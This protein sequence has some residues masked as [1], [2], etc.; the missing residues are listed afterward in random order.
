[1][2]LDV[3][4][5]GDLTRDGEASLR[6]VE[7]A[8]LNRK[9]GYRTG[10]VHLG[11]TDAPL[12]PAIIELI[13]GKIAEAL[14]YFDTHSGRLII[15]IDPACLLRAQPRLPFRLTGDRVVAVL[16][17]PE[18]TG[19][20]EAIHGRLVQLLGGVTS[21]TATAYD[22]LHELRDAGL[23]TL[24]TIWETFGAITQTP[25][26]QH[27]QRQSRPIVGTA[28]FE[29]AEH[30]PASEA[31]RHELWDCRS[32]RVQV[33]GTPPRSGVTGWQVLAPLERQ[34]LRFVSRLSAFLYFPDDRPRSLPLTA[35]GACLAA[36]I[37][38]FVAPHLQPAIGIGPRY[39]AAE[40]AA[41]ALM[42]L[43]ADRRLAGA[44][45]FD[46]LE[47]HRRRMRYWLGSPPALRPPAHS[48]RVML[49]ASNGDGLG[50]V[51]RLLAIARKLPDDVTPVFASLSS[52]IG[53]IR[54]AGF[55]AE[56]ILSHRYANLE[57]SIAY[58]W[59]AEELSEIVARHQPDAFV[60]D[61]GNPYGFMTEV[62]ARRRGLA[63]L[64]LRR[65]MWQE[66]QNNDP[67]LAKE[68]YF[69]AII[70]PS[71]LAGSA[72]RGA[73][74]DRRDGIVLTN[75]IRLVDDDEM[76]SHESA[77][78]A[79]GLDPDR[80]AVLLQLGIGNARDT[81]AATARVISELRQAGVQI[82]SLV[83]PMSHAVHPPVPGV[84]Q[85]AIYPVAPYLAA[86]DFAVS[87]AGYNS[88]HELLGAGIPT[89]F[90]VTMRAELD[91]QM[92]R[93]RYAE[94]IGAGYALS[95]SDLSRLP[96]VVGDVLSATQAAPDHR[97]RSPI[98]ANGA[99][100]AARLIA[101]FAR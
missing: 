20:L 73:T 33:A 35:I 40:S 82:V 16:E 69:E 93:A 94:T 55:P 65:G 19:T 71:D 61:G 32:Y 25:D 5:L 27:W 4:Y 64:W 49:F 43:L 70:E 45:R 59:M 2:N 47:V 57:P 96:G 78:E 8:R 101:E 10:L 68:K 92:A 28:V 18:P 42:E 7:E 39:V 11:R 52:G 80:P 29:G 51:T 21:W 36:G 22:A 67:V 62:I 79:L 72:D 17:A 85:M 63:Y 14:D 34:H 23:A 100:E 24:G 31:L 74:A 30:W 54:D 9:L 37:P 91:D 99:L 13:D 86:F 87:A 15:A 90:A 1:M 50:H 66:A 60:F 95:T 84:K 97:R 38:V 89:I 6:L 46:P 41:K 56:M 48:K 98:E 75:P 81:T 58:P 88:F 53:V 83:P 76:L 3:I 77:R 26:R 12:V 44:G